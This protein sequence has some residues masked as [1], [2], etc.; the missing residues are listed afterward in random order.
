MVGTAVYQVGLN[1]ASQ[2][3]KLGAMNPG[4]QI[5]LPPAC[6][7]ASSAATSP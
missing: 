1:S 4:V 7:D 5:T 2:S 6:S 3:K